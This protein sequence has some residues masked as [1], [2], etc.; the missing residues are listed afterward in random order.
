MNGLL[1]AA[2]EPQSPNSRVRETGATS[3]TR[4]AG[5]NISNTLE[6]VTDLSPPRAMMTGPK[7]LM[8]SGP[9][10][11]FGTSS[12]EGSMLGKHAPDHAIEVV[13]LVKTYPRVRA[14]QRRSR[15]VD[16]VSFSVESGTIFALLGPNGAG[17]STLIK[18]LTTLV[19]PDS[20]KASVMGFDVNNEPG[21]VRRM[22]GVVAQR[23]GMVPLISGR[24]NLMLQG[25]V[26]GLRG[27]EL[28]RRTEELLERFGLSEAATRPLRTYSG[29]MRRRLDLAVGLIHRP[30]ILILDEPTTGLDPEGR[31]M[32]W[33]DIA[34]LA[35][36]KHLTVLLTTHYLEEADQ[37]ADR[38]VIL[39][40]GRVV[41][42]GTSDDLRSGVG[43]DLL[44][45][46]L[47]TLSADTGEKVHA[48]LAIV[49]GLRELFVDGH[50]ITA[51]SDDAVAALPDVLAVLSRY[52]VPVATAAALRPSL[53]EVYFQHTEGASARQVARR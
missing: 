42:Q 50:R 43:G 34:E 12:Q 29:G 38:V 3:A 24:D 32:L 1:Q 2:I 37:L 18:V 21:H 27:G 6:K 51:R 48:S 10:P 49:P 45:I 15:V 17:K 33:T 20:G 25:R 16:G 30:Q 41:A 52:D 35:D 14:G 40:R 9:R 47:R 28:R 5:G 13:D 22:I 53:N 46:E 4:P 11:Q 36:R 31:R 8:R 19:R 26:F 44:R 39:D 7:P 23:S